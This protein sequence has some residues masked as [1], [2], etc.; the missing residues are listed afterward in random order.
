MFILLKAE[1]LIWLLRV[2]GSL[3]FVLA[4]RDAF[5]PNIIVPGRYTA[6]IDAIREMFLLEKVA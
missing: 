3:I 4:S 5:F 6:L 2:L 1:S